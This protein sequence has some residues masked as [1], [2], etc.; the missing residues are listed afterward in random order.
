MAL[1]TENP[2]AE[3]LAAE[4]ADEGQEAEDRVARWRR[5][6]EEEV[7]PNI[8]PDAR[9]KRITK[10]EREEILGYGPDGV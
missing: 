10:E 3:R 1:T 6:L 2:D 7:W 5:F 4:V 8:S 9:G